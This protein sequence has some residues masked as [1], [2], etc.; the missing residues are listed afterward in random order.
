MAFPYGART[1]SYVAGDQVRSADLNAI[2]DGIVDVSDEVEDVEDVQLPKKTVSRSNNAE[3]LFAPAPDAYGGE[4]MWIERS[5]NGLT[6]VVLDTLSDWRDRWIVFMGM[7]SDGTDRPGQV[8]D[9]NC[10]H[11]LFGAGSVH[12]AAASGMFYSGPGRTGADYEI[13]LSPAGMTDK[14][15]LYARA[16]DG[17]LCMVKDA[18]ADADVYLYLKVDGSPVQNHY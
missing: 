16:A 7:V 6:E 15:D 11:I 9:I 18:T 14:I 13:V 4:T 17:A 2:Q 10:G 8:G 12:S 3:L 1:H 5:T